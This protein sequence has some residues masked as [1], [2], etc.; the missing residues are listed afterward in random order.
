MSS[1][2]SEEELKTKPHGLGYESCKKW[3][4]QLQKG[5]GS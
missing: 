3:K 1:E 5:P 2:E 4:E